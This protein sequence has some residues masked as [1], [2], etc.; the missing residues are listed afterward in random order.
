MKRPPLPHRNLRCQGEFFD[1]N[2]QC[3]ASAEQ[4][5]KYRLPKALDFL[6]WEALYGCCFLKFKLMRRKQAQGEWGRILFHT[7]ITWAIAT[8][9]ALAVTTFTNCQSSYTESTFV[10]QTA[11]NLCVYT[12]ACVKCCIHFL[13]QKLSITYTV[14]SFMKQSLGIE[15]HIFCGILTG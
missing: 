1:Y 8:T 3:S 15:N 5:H 7:A 4:K 6:W 13:V 10:K 14:A 2:N 12:L 9:F 11:R